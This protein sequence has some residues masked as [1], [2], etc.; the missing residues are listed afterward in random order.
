MLEQFSCGQ[1]GANITYGFK[2]I[3]P[4]RPNTGILTNHVNM[5][6]FR[7]HEANMRAKTLI[8]MQFCLLLQ[9]S[10]AF[11]ED[12]PDGDTKTGSREYPGA[13]SSL[14]GYSIGETT[15]NSYLLQ[16]HQCLKAGYIDK[17]I[18]YCQKAINKDSNDCDTHLMYAQAL[19]KKLQTQPADK[20]DPELFKKCLAE[21][22]IVLRNEVGDEIGMSWHGLSVPGLSGQYSDTERGGVARVELK[23]LTGSLPRVWETDAKYIKRV[24]N[25]NAAR[26]AGKVVDQDKDGKPAKHKIEEDDE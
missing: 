26:V 17:A 18:K 21:Y 10:V 11:A 20:R 14:E 7:L 23:K 2:L 3:G 19:Q 8:A 25:A 12:G 13:V 16:A 6:V 9:T 24:G 22:L 4:I 1:T 5:A 15:G